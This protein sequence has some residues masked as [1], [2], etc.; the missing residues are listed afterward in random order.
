MSA[1]E[2]TKTGNTEVFTRSPTRV[3]LQETPTGRYFA[4][5][6][7]WTS[8]EGPAYNFHTGSAALES[9]QKLRLKNVQIVV[10]Q[11]FKG[12]NTF[13]VSDRGA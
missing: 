6:G 13:V 12:F 3:Y 5:N 10:L 1:P 7:F 4:S 2:R 8:S 9:A 11:Q